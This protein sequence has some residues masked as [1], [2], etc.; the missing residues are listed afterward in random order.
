M[1]TS[2]IICRQRHTKVLISL[3]VFVLGDISI[4][5][6]DAYFLMDLHQTQTTKIGRGRRG[7]NSMQNDM[8]CT[9]LRR[10]TVLMEYAELC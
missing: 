6:V 7:K 1:H 8:N 10:L 2:Y 9:E 5:E 3:A 4:T